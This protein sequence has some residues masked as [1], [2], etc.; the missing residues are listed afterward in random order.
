MDVN[1]EEIIF[2]FTPRHKFKSRNSTF[3]ACYVCRY[4][5]VVLSRL[6]NLIGVISES[7]QVDS[8]PS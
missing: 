7:G 5:N 6:L 4:F 3:I 1:E 8:S 2:S